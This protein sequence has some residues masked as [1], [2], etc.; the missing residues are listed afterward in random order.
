MRWINWGLAVAVVYT[1]FAASTLGFVAFAM[2]HPVQLVSPDYY[3][4]SL[5][6]DHRAA[7]AERA[8][9]L[10]DRLRLDLDGP[11]GVL[12]VALPSEASVG[13][14]GAIT[15]YRPSDVHADR[16]VVL[17]PDAAGR[18]RVSVA[19]LARGRWLVRLE[20]VAGGRAYFRETGIALR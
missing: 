5:Q 18:Q 4:R 3:E 17:V 1:L 9:A 6:Q 19:G 10:G 12:D 13:V 15:F 14:R 20:W 8:R 16:T 11:G 7:A 2:S